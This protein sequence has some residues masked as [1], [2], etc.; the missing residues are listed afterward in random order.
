MA[1]ESYVLYLM[2][3]LYKG[4]NFGFILTKLFDKAY[5][6]ADL[7]DR[8]FFSFIENDFVF[9]KEMFS[10][11]PPLPMITR[12]PDSF[13]NS[14]SNFSIRI[15]VVGPTETISN[16]SFSRGRMIGPAW[17]IAASFTSTG[18]SLPSSTRRL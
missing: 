4:K 9:F 3:G 14:Y 11:I 5:M 17:K 18:S 8:F 1:V 12:T 16:L 7:F 6:F 15:L 10:F 2:Y 13:T